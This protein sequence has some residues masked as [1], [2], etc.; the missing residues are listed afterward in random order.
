MSKK[1]S[2]AELSAAVSVYLEMKQK[3]GSHEPY[4]KTDYYNKLSAEFGRTSKSFE[5]R[6]QNISHVMSLMGRTWVSGLRPAKNV[7]TNIIEQIERI[8]LM[9]SRVRVKGFP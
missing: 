7:G 9:Y 5:F 2:E 6:M 4:S 8:I 3:D 1:W